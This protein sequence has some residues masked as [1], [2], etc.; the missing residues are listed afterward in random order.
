VADSATISTTVERWTS[1]SPLPAPALTVLGLLVLLSVVAAG[2]GVW[3]E[4]IRWRKWSMLAFRVVIGAAVLA[5]LL[6]PGARQVQ[7]AAM[8]ARLAVVVD[9]SRS[10]Q[11]PV[12]AGG[13]SRAEFSNSV[14]R[15]LLKNL[16]DK[17]ASQQLA[18]ELYGFGADVKPVSLEDMEKNAP[19]DNRTDF[20]Q[21]F[22]ELLS[23]SAEESRR[24]S[25]V[26]I[27]SDGAD[28]QGLFGSGTESAAV[29]QLKALKIPVSTVLVGTSALKDLSVD[30][31][32][33]DEFAFVRNSMV[34]EVEISGRGFAGQT[35]PVVLRREGQVVANKTVTFDEDSQTRVV[36]FSFSPDQTGRFV[37]TVSV[38]VFP[39]EALSENNLKS[40]TLKVIRDRVRVLL[41]AGRPTWDERFVRGVL[42]A[43]PNVELVSFYILRT[44]TDDSNAGEG[45]L[46]LIPFP[47][48]EIFERKISTFDVV[49]AMNFGHN[50]QGTSLQPYAQSITNYVK[51]GG[52]L[53][54]IG[55]DASFGESRG[56]AFDGL[57]PLEAAGAANLEPFS[58][59]LTTQGERHPITSF[60]GTPA[61]AATAWSSLP[62]VPGLNST[63]AKPGATVLLEH[64]FYT[65]GGN[66]APLLAVWE[67]ERGRVLTLASDATWYWAF[68]SKAKGDASRLYERFWSQAIRWLVKD[69]D[70]TT[71]LVASDSAT[72]EPSQPIAVTAEAKL[73][74]YQAAVG[75][76]IEIELRSAE[77]GA[78]I[79]T[80]R[81]EVGADGVVKTEFSAQP[82]GAYK[83]VS[84]ATKDGKPIGEYAD[85][86]AVRANGSELND[87]SVNAPLLERI[88]AESGGRFFDNEA[89][90][91]DALPFAPPPSVEVGRAQD[92]PLWTQWQWFGLLIAALAAEW[93]LRR[94]FGYA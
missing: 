77:S 60:R 19:P 47:R 27:L 21:L 14:T 20:A 90:H 22:R 48:D 83:I 2:Y 62:A 16:S 3:R 9:R 32:K 79:E 8:R 44:G 17:Q 91:V 11:F 13:E 29:A 57:L 93:M 10:M 37:Y 58:A 49:V 70:L 15:A 7:I 42:R 71:L 31:V 61:G 65:I 68:P 53:A 52:A 74:D 92:R 76:S 59:R 36:E 94:R 45:E 38:P 25:G 81:V 12:R 67:Q 63:R 54:Y 51:K 41:I 43:D 1:L 30:N 82:A 26:L 73:N 89:P 88:A 33:M 69:P 23:E 64:P 39:D 5:L 40:V 86:V 85:G 66:N 6:E 78:L 84:K 24:P 28:T 75:A 46:S 18:V 87:V 72:V 4:A 34:A 56:T 35:V 80:K 50:E 55:G